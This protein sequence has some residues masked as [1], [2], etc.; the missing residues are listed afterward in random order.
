MRIPRWMVVASILLG[1]CSGGSPKGALQSVKQA[2]NP[3]LPPPDTI[4][5]M[6][7]YSPDLAVNLSDMAKLPEG[8]LWQDVFPGDSVAPPAVAGDSVEIAFEGWLPSG[9][10]VDSGLT[11]LRV[12][13]GSVMA[14]IDLA[15]AGM[16]TGGRRKLVL[17]PGLAY[18]AEGIGEIPPNSVLV[19]DLELRRIIR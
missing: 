2:L 14:G 13:S 15:V 11:A 18:G 3:P 6:L 10:K 12:G 5:E 1:G 16:R 8:V 19:Y 4:P 9:I 7:D 17:P